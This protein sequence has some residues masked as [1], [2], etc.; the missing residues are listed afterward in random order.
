[1]ILKQ[2]ENKV[3]C[4]LHADRQEWPP[5]SKVKNELGDVNTVES[6]QKVNTYLP[7]PQIQD[8]SMSTVK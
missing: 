4:P 1:M 2:N 8:I 5:K 3:V 6:R 7:S